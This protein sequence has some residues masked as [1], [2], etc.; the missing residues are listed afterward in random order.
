M[1]DVK[2]CYAKVRIFI[3]QGIGIKLL[4][5][6]AVIAIQSYSVMIYEIMP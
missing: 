6:K 2:I 4:N 5:L 1:F 3:R